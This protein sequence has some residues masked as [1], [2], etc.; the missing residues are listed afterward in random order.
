MSVDDIKQSR[1]RVFL[2]QTPVGIRKNSFDIINRKLLVEL[3]TYWK[4]VVPTYTMNPKR[5]CALIMGQS[6]T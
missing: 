6:E 4:L 5:D 1:P 2:A 3:Q